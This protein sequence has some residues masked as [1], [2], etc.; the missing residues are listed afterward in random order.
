M[1]STALAL[2]ANGHHHGHA[3][4]HIS[5]GDKAKA[6]DIIAAIRT[7][8]VVEREQRPATDD[9]MQAL[10]R[11]GGFGA[12]A[13]SIFPDPVTGEYKP[14]WRETGEELRSLLSP[15]EY[16]SAKRTTFSQFFTS[17]AVMEAMHDALARFG[18]PDQAVILEPG[19]GSGNFL[20][21]GKPGQ[22]FIGV[23]LD[24]LTG[25]IARA[26]HPKA[27]IRIENFR[28]SKLPPLDAVIG[29]IPFANVH[30]D[31]HG[32]KLSLHDYCIAK[33]VEALKPGGVLAVVTSHFTLDKQNAAVREMLAGQADFL[34]A[35]RLPN[36][37]FKREGT[38]VTTDI[39]FLR[40]RAP[41][42]AA[43]HADPE[44][45]ETSEIGIQGADLPVNRY[46]LNHHEMVLGDWS[47]E[48][49]LHGAVGFSVKS[50][51][52]LASQLKEAVGRIAGAEQSVVERPNPPPKP[53][54]EGEVGQV[55][56]SLR[57]VTAPDRQVAPPFTPPPPLRHVT[58]GSLFVGDDKVI[59]QVENGE[60]QPVV[61]QGGVQRSDQGTTG[62][63]LACLID[64][65]DKARRVLQSQNEGWPE[66]NRSEARRTLNTAYDRFVSQYGPINKTTFTETKTGTIRR[67]PN[68]VKFRE[69]PDAMLV[70]A[71]E[72]YDEATGTAKK[73]PILLR[74]VVGPKPPVTHVASAEEGLL[75]SLNERGGIDLPY[76]ASLY[77]KPEQ[78]VITELDD[79]IYR[80]PETRRWQ[81]RDEYLSGN[82]RDKLRIAEKAGPEY[83][84][85]AEALRQVQPEDV[86]PGDIDANL[87]APWI[88]A[89]DVKAFAESLFG[90]NFTVGHLKKDAVWSVEP[91]YRAI[92]SVA[93]TADFGT[94]RING[95]ELLSMAMNQKSPVIYDT[96]YENGSET[97]VINPTETQA[98][99]EK[100]KLIKERF[101]SWVFSDPDRTERLVR[102]YND[103]YNNLRPR[104]FDG[105]HLDFPGMS[106]VLELRQHQK[107]AVWRCM[108][109]G[110]TLLA[111]VVGAGKTAVMAAGAMKMRQAGL[112]KKPLIVVPN[113]ML[114]QVGRE[115][116]QWYPNAKVLVATK[117]DFSKERR[118]V[119]T[120]KIATGDWDAIIVTHSSFE[121]IGMSREYQEKFLREQI[122]EYEALLVDKASHGRNI[123]KTLE[124]QK[125]NREE[126]LKDLLAGDKKD[127]GLVFDELGVDHVFVD[128]AHYFKNLE[129]PTK[130]ERVAG[131]QTGGSE[132]AFDL[133]MK[134]RYLDEQ[135]PGHGVTFATGTPISNTMVEMYT[136]QRF[137]DPKGLRDRGIEHFDAWAATF[138]EVVDAMEISPD[139]ASLRPRSRFARFVNLPELIQSF[140]AFSDVQTAEMLNLPRPKLEGGKPQTIACPMSDAQVALQGELIERYDAIR[141]TK[142][143]PR[144]DNALAITTDGRKLALDGRML[145][146]GGDFEESKINALVR[147]VV[148]IWRKTE[149]TRGTQMIFCDMGV[150]ANPFSAYDEI[151]R[152]LQQAGIPASQIAVMG[153]A[154]TDAKKQALFEKV[155]QGTV[156]VILGSTAK[157][158]T[159][160]NVQKRLVAMHHLDAPWKPAEVEQR[161]GRILRQ[162]NENPEV[163]IYRYVTEGSFDAYMWQALETKARF[164][165]QIMSGDCAVR[166]ADDI[167]DQELSYAE[168]KAIASGNPAVLTLAETDAEL[169]RL[170]ILRKNH[171]DGQ[172]LARKNIRDLPDDIKRL[173]KRLDGLTADMATMAG[174]KD[175]PSQEFVAERLKRMPEKVSET[176]RTPLGKYRGLDASM[177]LHPLGGTEV[178][179]DGATRCRETLMRDNPGPRAVLNALERLA[180][181]YDHACRANRGEISMKQGQLADFQAR[182][183]QVFEHGE[184]MSQLADLRDK[185]RDGLSE[186]AQQEPKPE[187]PTVA[188]LAQRI[189]ELRAL[190]TVEATPERTVRKAVRAERPVTARLKEKLGERQVEP[191]QA[192]VT[193]EPVTPEPVQVPA[194]VVIAMPEPVNGHAKA[195]TKRRQAKAEQLRLF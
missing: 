25:R 157:M 184:Y 26:L 119:L 88:P 60:G 15:E 89:S 40:K 169:Q 21:H 124:K 72:E 62:K 164:I 18:V 81:T 150:N 138:G 111:H 93:A 122:K 176:Y 175:T 167:G 131:I 64:L 35:I 23:E 172:Y 92:Q 12:V 102:V 141:N 52:D 54:V 113:H 47:R 57:Q 44:W 144:K 195:V 37:A 71:L 13:L 133:Y 74:D 39:L 116:Q 85:N 101:K 51:G 143:D 30:L 149:A 193:P 139:G 79:L 123:I 130:M 108:T 192:E 32:Q 36:D 103:T 14:G 78:A 50:N 100:Q 190:N 186:K 7:L 24:S 3:N 49:L 58:E 153:D 140:L 55:E 10:R 115:F 165:A 22:R 136:M 76:I 159:G 166:K 160:T 45:L 82:V 110:N 180:N 170:A 69:D 94:S 185:L 56:A 91:D 142:V 181:G 129:T 155:R 107:D 194:P 75:V 154:D 161:D 178:V 61:Y 171:A 173:E 98:A 151:V 126:K 65:R 182:L 33:S 31:F 95:T 9:E 132:R 106:T 96:V 59:R 87:G 42:Q 77:G 4:G 117:E 29:N 121:R 63:R 127:D 67:M 90:G 99:K 174:N 188:E 137:L 6:R 162:G 147:N 73:A 125:A 27:D 17:P 2:P 97:R 179:L 84:R 83:A 152:K 70:M 158:G 183:G 135:H 118:K 134:C 156:R 41:G 80:D 120:A 1:N 8:K 187:G 163:A 146:A 66:A 38:A 53:Q 128:E 46:F 5:T 86:L 177:I 148:R 43:N 20:S 105:S 11:F 28:D 68:L 104:L 48:H 168:V 19:C 34:G 191:V 112:I 145:G 109:G 16:D 114:E 189:H